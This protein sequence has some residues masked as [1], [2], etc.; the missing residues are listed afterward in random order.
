M[1]SSEYK[2]IITLS[3]RAISFEYLLA[4]GDG[5]LAPMGGDRWP[6]PMAFFAAGNRIILGEEALNAHRNGQPDTFVDYFN[7]IKTE[8]RFTYGTTNAPVAN[9]LLYAVEEQLRRFLKE[10]LYGRLG[11]LEQN[12]SE[13]PLILAFNDDIEEKERVHVIRLFQDSG[14]NNLR[15]VRYNWFVSKY[16]AM[17]HGYRHTLMAWSD[18]VDLHLTTFSK[19]SP[20]QIHT[21][22][23]EGLG[24]DPRVSEI[25][26]IIWKDV[27]PQAWYPDFGRELPR[28]EEAAREFLSSGRPEYDG[29]VTMS[30]GTE[31]TYYLRR[32]TVNRISLHESQRLQHEL[33]AFLEQCGC[34]DRS[35]TLLLLRGR[36]VGNDYFQGQLNHGFARM[37]EV[38]DDLRRAVK[39]LLTAPDLSDASFPMTTGAPVAE[40]FT[41]PSPQFEQAPIQRPKRKTTHTPTP[42]ANSPVPKPPVEP[43]RPAHNPVPAPPIEVPGRLREAGLPEHVL[44]HLKRTWKETKAA[45]TGKISTR[46]FDEAYHLL[47][48]FR[49]ECKELDYHGFDSDIDQT[50]SEIKT[51]EAKHKAQPANLRRQ[52]TPDNPFSGI[53]MQADSILNRGARTVPIRPV[54]STRTTSPSRPSRPTPPPPGPMPHSPNPEPKA[55]PAIELI[56]QGKLREARDYYRNHGLTTLA[57]ILTDIYRDKRSI[58]ARKKGLDQIRATH[59]TQQAKRI[60]DE[61]Q[62]YIDKCDKVGVPCEDIKKLLSEYRKV[63]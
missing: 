2:V 7:D 1:N 14:Y 23:L 41:P 37:I 27:E 56:R 28:L 43:I 42:P 15:P 48:T 16:F 38:N 17:N 46:K 39:Q 20:E 47:N 31:C 26:K 10:E 11:G 25:A 58:E 35:G 57:A 40:Q 4:G 21:I 22:R 53:A 59:N 54:P 12:R 44:R 24:I 32:D 3:H 55:D 30:D 51:Q 13:M 34:S 52:T 9:V 62:S 18:G 29:T 19:Q 33:T 45:A 36:A 5:S 6:A 49:R 63:K 61:L 8:R 60:V 50:F